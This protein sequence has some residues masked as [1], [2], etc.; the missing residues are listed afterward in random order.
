[1]GRSRDAQSWKRMGDRVDMS[2]SVDAEEFDRVAIFAQL[3]RIRVDGTPYL[4]TPLHLDRHG[5]TTMNAKS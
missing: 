2:A 1:M 3:P 5:M 4:R